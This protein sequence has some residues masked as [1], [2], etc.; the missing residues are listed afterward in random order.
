MRTFPRASAATRWSS[1][2]FPR[3]GLILLLAIGVLGMHGFIGSAAV[4]EMRHA[5]TPAVSATMSHPIAPHTTTDAALAPAP[6]PA[7]TMCESAC[8][9][10]GMPGHTS[11][12]TMCALALLIGLLL[13][14]RPPLRRITRALQL[15]AA[16]I[17]PRRGLRPPRPPSLLVLSISRT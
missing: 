5:G 11:M 17:A 10:G 13:L 15:A 8:E 12:P 7:A 2:P 1:T 3:L 16:R 6:G 14:L 9:G 4:H